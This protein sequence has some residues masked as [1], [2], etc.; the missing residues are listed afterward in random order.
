MS[1]WTGVEALRVYFEDRADRTADI[2][3][4]GDVENTQIFGNDIIY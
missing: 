3:G 1:S 4:V 2:V